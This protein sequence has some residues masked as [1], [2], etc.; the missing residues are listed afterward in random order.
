[1][2]ETFAALPDAVRRFRPKCPGCTP[3]RVTRPDARPC[4]FYDCS[5]L[6]KELEVT[7]DLCMYD[8]ATDDGQIKCDH[9]T[10][11]AAVRLKQ[12]VETYKAWVRLLEAELAVSP[13]ETGT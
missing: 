4:S 6:P 9:D 2:Q 10:C 13:V 7:C 8:F 1:M 12:N 11:E 3:A 5:G